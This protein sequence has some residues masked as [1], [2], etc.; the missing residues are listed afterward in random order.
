M[1]GYA[2]DSFNPDALMMMQVENGRRVVLSGGAS[3][4]LLVI[5]ANMKMNPAN[6]I[7]NLSIRK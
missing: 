5:P 7:G 3:Y 6:R 2:Y 1:N 4:K